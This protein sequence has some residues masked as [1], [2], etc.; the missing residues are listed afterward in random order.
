MPARSKTTTVRLSVEAKAKLDQLQARITLDVG[1]RLTKEELLEHLIDLG[2]RDPSDL[3]APRRRTEAGLAR[4]LALPQKTGVRT[5]PSDID[6]V[7]YG[8]R[9]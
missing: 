6:D 7:L 5:K 9:T 2:L 8:A 1:E 3:V 4:L